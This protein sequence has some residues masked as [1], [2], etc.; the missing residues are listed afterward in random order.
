MCKIRGGGGGISL[1]VIPKHMKQLIN[2]FSMIVHFSTK[3]VEAYTNKLF[4][5][6]LIILYIVKI[7]SY[8]ID[9][10]HTI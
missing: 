2:T 1:M 4:L 10:I 7:T 9:K 6:K 3:V 5:H 8:R